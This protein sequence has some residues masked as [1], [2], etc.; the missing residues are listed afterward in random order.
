MP[1][2]TWQEP[3]ILVDLLALNL[4]AGK[5]G[6]ML[7]GRKEIA[8]ISAWLSDVELFTR[9][10]PWGIQVAAGEVPGAITLAELLISFLNERWEVHVAVLAYGTSPS[11][12]RKDRD[13]FPLE[14]QLLQR[15][16]DRG[17]SV[18]LLR[19]LHAKGLV[20]PLGLVTGSTNITQSGLFL[21]S[22]NTNYFSY[23]HPDFQSNRTHLYSLF[24]GKQRECNMRGR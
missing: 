19:D 8:I 20:T 14:R 24:E 2:V 22:Q 3:Q 17:A 21:Q 9:P 7:P 6:M 1:N 11:G 23:E 15:L 10:G 4:L 5:N 13:Q 16:I 18:Y 12:L